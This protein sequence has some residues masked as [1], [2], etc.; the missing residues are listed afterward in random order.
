MSEMRVCKKCGQEKPIDLFRVTRAKATFEC[1]ECFKSYMREWHKN[2]SEQYKKKWSDIRVEQRRIKRLDPEFRRKDDLM[3]IEWAKNKFKTDPEYR[4]KRRA[5]DA[6]L[7]KTKYQSN[8]ERREML[9]AISRENRRNLCISYVAHLLS[10]ERI[11]KFPME[12][13]EVKKLQI[14]IHRLLQEKQ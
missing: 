12:V 8:D 4:K 14:Q 6:H 9:K 1:R 13:L 11:K 3:K 10:G 7:K 5:Y 2:T